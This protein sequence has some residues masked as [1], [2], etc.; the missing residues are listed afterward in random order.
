MPPQVRPHSAANGSHASPNRTPSKTSWGGDSRPQTA[1]ATGF[2]TTYTGFNNSSGRQNVAT[3]AA[4]PGGPAGMPSNVGNYSKRAG[5]PMSQQNQTGPGLGASGIGQF[6]NIYNPNTSQPAPPAPPGVGSGTG[7][8]GK[9]FTPR[10]QQF[11]AGSPR[12]QTPRTP[13]TMNATG[14]SGLTG[15]SFASN[16]YGGSG[17][18]PYYNFQKNTNADV[19][20]AQNYAEKYGGSS[21]GEYNYDSDEP[22]SPDNPRVKKDVNAAAVPQWQPPGVTGSKKDDPKDM[23][24]PGT[25][26]PGG[27]GGAGGAGGR[28]TMQGGKVVD[29]DGGTTTKKKKAYGSSGTKDFNRSGTQKN[30]QSMG[31]AG[32]R[33]TKW[34]EDSRYTASPRTDAGGGGG[35]QQYQQYQSGKQQYN[36]TGKSFAGSPGKGRQ[37]TRR[38]SSRLDDADM[39]EYGSP[40]DLPFGWALHRTDSGIVVILIVV[41]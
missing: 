25:A 37:M 24:R 8:G 6:K 10:Q 4:S 38:M 19:G 27:S 18:N 35:G 29:V 16:T 2:N 14:G 3:S 36:Q 1:G 13:R 33:G 31:G 21:G 7:S 26:P 20:A 15:Q 40:R 5:P 30:F 41:V 17:S 28:Y 12:D 34:E 23:N 22:G 39:S 32:A 11:G 9:Q